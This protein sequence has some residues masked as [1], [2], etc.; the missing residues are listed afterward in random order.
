MF[1]MN[2]PRSASNA[3][4]RSRRDF[5][6]PADPSEHP[7]K[8]NKTEEEVLFGESFFDGI[9]SDVATVLESGANM[10]HSMFNAA[11]SFFS[12]AEEDAVVATQEV[13]EM[14]KARQ[15]K[16]KKS[17][18]DEAIALARQNDALKMRMPSLW[19][20]KDAKRK[21]EDSKKAI[22]KAVSQS[23]EQS[24]G[25]GSSSGGGARVKEG[26][27]VNLSILGK[28]TLA[29]F[30]CNDGHVLIIGNKRLILTK[31]LSVEEVWVIA[32]E[33]K[34]TKMA[35]VIWSQVLTQIHS[36]A[37]GFT[38]EGK[39]ELNMIVGKDNSKFCISLP[40]ASTCSEVLSAIKGRK[41]GEPEDKQSDKS[42]A[43]V[44]TPEVSRKVE[45]VEEEVVF[46]TP[47]SYA[48]I[49]VCVRQFKHG[50]GELGIKGKLIVDGMS[51][52]NAEETVR[53]AK[54]VMGGKRLGLIPSKKTKV[55]VEFVDKGESGGT[56]EIKQRKVGSPTKKDEIQVPVTN[57]RAKEK[58]E[59]VCNNSALA[60]NPIEAMLN[61]RAKD[62]GEKSAASPKSGV[63]KQETSTS[64]VVD[65]AKEAGLRDTGA[66]LLKDHPVYAKYFKM[67]KVSIPLGAVKAKM[68]Q[69][70][71]DPSV[72]DQLPNDFYT[73]PP[74]S[75]G[76]KVALSS[77]SSNDGVALKDHPVYAKYFK[78]LK[79]S[80]PLGAVKAKMAQE[81]L[82]P[83]VLDQ[84]P[85]SKVGECLSKPEAKDAVPLKEH[86]IYAKYFKM[87]KVGLPPPQVKNKMVQEGADP[88]VLDKDPTEKLS[89]AANSFGDELA[90]G[91]SISSNATKN[92]PR[93]KKMYWKAIEKE[94]ID[95]NSLWANDE[96]ED[97]DII[98]DEQ[99]F[100]MLFVESVNSPKKRA[101]TTMSSESNT[102]SKASKKQVTYLI[103]MKRGQN[104]SIALSRIK[105]SYVEV[106]ENIAMMED[107]PFSADQLDF[108]LEY[109]PTYEE[110][111]K[112]K[113]FK[114]DMDSLGQPEKFMLE[115]STLDK[116]APIIEVLLYKKRFND[117]MK[118][119]ACNVS[120]VE[121]A[122]DDV[123][124]SKSLKKVMKTILK[125]GNQMNSDKDNEAFA[126]TLDSLLKLQTAK[127]FDKKTSILQYVIMLIHRNDKDCLALPEDLCHIAEASRITMEQVE[128]ERQ[129]LK[130]GLDDA[131]N[132]VSI[133]K[134]TASPSE[135]MQLFL[136]EASNAI[137]DLDTQVNQV[138]QKYA[139]V[140]VYFGENTSMSSNEF[141]ETLNK[142]VMAFSR[143]R[144]FFQAKLQREERDA[145]REQR[146]AD[147]PRPR[148]KTA[149]QATGNSRAPLLDEILGASKKQ[150]SCSG[151]GEKEN[152]NCQKEDNRL[153]GKRRASM[154]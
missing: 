63:Q 66:I 101:A 75:A 2:G 80:I 107:E 58:E 70:G 59:K 105:M 54:K 36:C 20:A 41:G 68:A 123:K 120:K 30:Q 22:G 135:S 116:A 61:A 65:A 147:E 73:S 49:D 10:G 110:Q 16:A 115:M 125:V 131:I 29:S 84:G 103:D 42:P 154:H 141:F 111:Q 153:L 87:L 148:T 127:A 48:R 32:K 11:F 128:A 119:T 44:G 96:N 15:S 23:N 1:S 76:A 34:E 69:E 137:S 138:K 47:T 17:S 150:L 31:A 143:D 99:E 35:R 91:T 136:H 7:A 146:T 149:S 108:L 19:N 67:L 38:G 142:F 6:G 56:I 144:E 5:D 113:S 40:S 104:A 98:V 122:C 126:F 27:V 51:E 39:T 106:R 72:L 81:G 82:D 13:E 71:L 121:R 85:D 94:A 46:A 118:E 79:V 88:S 132:L 89:A 14:E 74:A 25:A 3:T 152:S 130:Q 4:K 62:N 133:L 114:G 53:K 139:N 86:P 37:V 52:D 55:S 90:A 117:R 93:K 18:I 12:E 112:L 24:A 109:L 60:T 43:K 50:V 8:V 78:M 21:D 124:L 92:Q 57:A 83:S 26:D 102:K 134:K 100:K 151:D 77:T 28:T 95:K 45:E 145:A 9:T 64:N 129:Q 140:L 33:S 97:E